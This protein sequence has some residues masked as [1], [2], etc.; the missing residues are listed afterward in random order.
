MISF[1]YNNIGLA[2]VIPEIWEHSD[3]MKSDKTKTIEFR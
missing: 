2:K 3:I 1:S